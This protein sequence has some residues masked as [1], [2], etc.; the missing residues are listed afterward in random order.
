MSESD[1]SNLESENDQD[2]WKLVPPKQF[3]TIVLHELRTPITIIKG[4]VDLLSNEKQKE[5]HPE[6]IRAISSSIERMEKLYED[7]MVYTRELVQ[8]SDT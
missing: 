4:H 3:L 5:Y 1:S 8:K 2:N 7:M 6:A